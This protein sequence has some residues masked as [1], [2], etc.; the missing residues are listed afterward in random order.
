MSPTQRTLKALRE[1]GW[2]PA[3][4]EKWLARPGIRQ[5]L[6]GCIDI[7]ALRG[8]ETLAIQCTSTGVSARVKKIEELPALATMK[9]AGWRVE[10]WG[11]RKLKSGWEPRKVTL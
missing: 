3:V 11:W 2:L 8:Q 10:V 7:L 5:D 1:D 6:F 9:A 4:V